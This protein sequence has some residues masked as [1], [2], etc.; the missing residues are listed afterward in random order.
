MNA[1]H[2]CRARKRSYEQLV[3]LYPDNEEYK[4]YAAQTLYKVGAPLPEVLCMSRA[5]AKW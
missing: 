4:L 2:N 1:D 3:T 5:V